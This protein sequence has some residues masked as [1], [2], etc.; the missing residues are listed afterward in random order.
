MAKQAKSPV[1]IR[2]R[3]GKQLRAI[4]EKSG[5]TLAEA[6]AY[7]GLVGPTLSKIENGKQSIGIGNLR[8]LLQLYAVDEEAH[9]ELLSEGIQAS[10]K[11][12][13]IAYADTVPEW[14]RVFIGIESDADRIL[15]YENEFIPGLLQVEDYSAAIRRAARVEVT[16]ED[17]RRSASL[18]RDRQT[19][20]ESDEPPLF[21]AVINEGVLHRVVGS[22]SV[23]RAQLDH[24][25]TKAALDHVRVQVL[26]FSAGAHPAMNGA[27]SILEF[28][29][30]E[31]ST[32]YVE[33]ESG[34]LY[35]SRQGDMARYRLMFKQLTDLALDERAS[36]ALI[37][38]LAK[39]L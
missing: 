32:A 27:F 35:P 11:D 36:L 20:L 6:A 34:G 7:V 29:E 16:E 22:P 39:R 8:A 28:E 13:W 18:R 1:L 24:L 37:A 25:V 2:R 26:P 23:M 21:H 5:V 17:A 19:H 38:E 3:L 10:K 9:S 15:T 31:L 14:F 30:E 4:R 12:W 33:I